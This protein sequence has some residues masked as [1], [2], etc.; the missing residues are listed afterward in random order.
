[1]QKPHHHELREAQV[2]HQP[3]MVLGICIPRRSIRRAGGWPHG[4]RQV[5]TAMQTDF[6]GNPRIGLKR[7]RRWSPGIVEFNPR[8]H[9]RQ[10]RKPNASS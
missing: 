8:R 10:Q 4:V 7:G 9:K 1:M 6:P 2:I 5:T 3:E